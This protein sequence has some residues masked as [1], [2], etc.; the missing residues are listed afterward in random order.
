MGF[1]VRTLCVNIQPYFKCHISGTTR[2]FNTEQMRT[3]YKK[4][5]CKKCDCI[6]KENEKI[7]N[8]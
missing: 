1:K 6:S 7:K 3:N 4:I 2:Y 8:I 5:H